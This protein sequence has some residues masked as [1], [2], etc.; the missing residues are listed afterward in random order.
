MKRMMLFIVLLWVL[1]SQTGAA[2]PISVSSRLDTSIILM[3]DQV[4]FS[5]R[6]VHDEGTQVIWPELGKSIK[7]DSIREIEIVS[8]SPVDTVRKSGMYY[9]TRS[10]LLTAFDS[11]Y[12]IIPPVAIRY[13]DKNLDSFQVVHT[14]PYLLT[15]RG[16]DIDTT[17]GFKPIKEPL[18]MPF[19]IREI[20]MELF[21]GAL[22]LA[23]LAGVLL[24]FKY[25]K[26][27]PAVIKR[28]VR[29]DPPHVIALERLRQLEEKKLW[30]QGEVKAYYSELSEIIRQYLEGRYNI[31]ALESTTEEILQQLTSFALNRQ[32]FEELARALRTA[33]FVKFAKAS[34][35]PDE[36]KKIMDSMVYFVKSTQTNQQSENQIIEE[37]VS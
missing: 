13:R 25:R 3:G 19:I 32:L 16:I 1:R 23:L 31:L 10:Y 24:Y 27:K 35:L 4:N 29:K 22:I 17:A 34:P 33:D 21:L 14:E 28:F 36:H 11:G 15:V 20:I 12:Y 6:V 30:Q 37:Q 26:K 7:V 2:S 9:E 18:K 5:I 8:V